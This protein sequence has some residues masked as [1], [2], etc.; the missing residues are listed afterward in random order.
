MIVCKGNYMHPGNL[1]KLLPWK[2]QI[3]C[4]PLD[5]TKT[6]PPFYFTLS[7]EMFS[8]VQESPPVGK[9]WSLYGL[10]FIYSYIYLSL[11]LFPQMPLS[12]FLE[13]FNAQHLKKVLSCSS[14]GIIS[15][16]MLVFSIHWFIVGS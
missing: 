16:G 11:N 6:T 3:K 12:T 7:L 5:Q 2:R 14:S 9:T 10:S 1:L 8:S 4:K 13:S 15:F